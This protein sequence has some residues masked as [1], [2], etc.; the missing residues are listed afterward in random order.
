MAS[1]ASRE[2]LV[3]LLNQAVE[4]LRALGQE[5][6]AS[7]LQRDRDLIEVGDFRGITQL[8]SA[9]G[10]MGS[11]NDLVFPA[12]GGAVFQRDAKLDEWLSRVYSVADELRREEDRREAI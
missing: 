1:K 8:L 3:T 9:F 12:E 2:F 4:R 10:G 11:I 7:R 6:W 5:Q